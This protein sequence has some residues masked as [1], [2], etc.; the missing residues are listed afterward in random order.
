MIQYKNIYEQVVTPQQF[1]LLEE[2]IIETIDDS[3]GNLKIMEEVRKGRNSFNKTYEYFLDI[4]E[5]KNS[6]VQHLMAQE[7]VRDIYIY[8]N[9]TNVFGYTVYDVE[10]YNEVD[11]SLI[12]KAKKI[13]DNQNRVIMY[14]D[15]D[16]VTNAILHF[17]SP[18][19]YYYDNN[20]PEL[21][22]GFKYRYDE[23]TQQYEVYAD[24]VN[25]CTVYLWELDIPKIISAFGQSFWDSHPYYHNVEPLLPTAANL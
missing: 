3:T 21:I 10:R 1:Q 13:F 4:T 16:I 18:R 25:E 20:D 15:L 2:Y 6:V 19:K 7:L 8:C 17:P 24:D 22:L 14:C 9:K 5:D 23:T 11:G 12:G